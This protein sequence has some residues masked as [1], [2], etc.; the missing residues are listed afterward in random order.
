MQFSST[1]VLFTTTGHSLHPVPIIYCTAGCFKIERQI[2]LAVGIIIT[3]CL[4]QIAVNCDT[5][6]IACVN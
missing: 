1:N 4:V 6:H 5:C 3:W 2:L